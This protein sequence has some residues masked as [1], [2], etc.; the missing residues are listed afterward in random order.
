MKKTYFVI[1]LI[2]IFIFTS[3]KEA[4]ISEN[5]QH[6][7]SVTITDS[8]GVE[9]T[10]SYPVKRVV[11]T[12]N[13]ALN[14]LY[15]LGAGETVVG[16]D[17]WTYDTE[18]VYK[19]TSKIDSRI[20]DKSIPAVDRNVEAIVALNPDVVI[21]WAENQEI[22]A[23]E[24]QGIPVI[25][26]QVNNFDDVYKK[27]EIMGAITGKTERA[28]E[29]IKYCND[30]L[31]NI[32]KSLSAISENEKKSSLFVWEEGQY[33]G[34]DSTGNSILL[35]S[36][37]TNVADSV[38]QENFAAT[39]EQIVEWNPSTIVM[40]HSLAVDTND[41]KNNSQWKDV[42]AV[43]NNAILELPS[44]FYCDLWTVKYINSINIIANTFYNEAFGNKNIQE[45]EAEIIKFLYNKEL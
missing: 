34:N 22:E 23:L 26:I 42:E 19:I 14:D 29:I 39:M 17:K 36:G 30:K 12:L 43:K 41:I 11:C 32:E 9:V 27:L 18:D 33:A 15:M 6:S 2:F 40:W 25:G 8:R 20:A 28:S 4:E 1:F 13:S 31:E 24:K 21:M 7:E 35:K 10:V 45:E 38:N 44:N 3:C 16:I 5:N 37:L